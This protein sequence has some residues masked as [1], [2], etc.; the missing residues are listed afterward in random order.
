[1]KESAVMPITAD[2]QQPALD[3]G[4]ASFVFRST[5]TPVATSCLVRGIVRVVAR[6]GS[7]MTAVHAPTA[8]AVAP[9]ANVQASLPLRVIEPFTTAT[10]SST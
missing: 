8:P 4:A 6:T 1:M 10:T 9:P 5:G 7:G 2:I 3:A